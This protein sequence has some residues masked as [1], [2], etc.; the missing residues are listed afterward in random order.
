M[1][2]GS[3]CIMGRLT[4]RAILLM[5][6]VDLPLRAILLNMKQWYGAHGCLVM[7]LFCLV[8][9]YT[10]INPGHLLGIV[11]TISCLCSRYWPRDDS[12]AKRTHSSV[13]GNVE[14]ATSTGLCVSYKT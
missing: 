2:E 6:S 10:G 3:F 12:S 4:A 13:M 14:Q 8:I 9:T 5:C 1:Y 7:G 11:L